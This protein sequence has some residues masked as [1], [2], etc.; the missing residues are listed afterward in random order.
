MDEILLGNVGNLSLDNLT[1]Y[2]GKL[3]RNAIK[4]NK[5][6]KTIRNSQNGETSF[7]VPTE[8]SDIVDENSEKVICEYCNSCV[9]N[10]K[11]HQKTM[12][13]KKKQQE[14]LNHA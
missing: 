2:L 4:L 9:I 14:L 1:D 11:K 5:E 6:L 7:A 12:S 3:Q 13:C 10:I 8:N